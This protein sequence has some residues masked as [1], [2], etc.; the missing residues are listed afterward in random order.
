MSCSIVINQ[1]ASS[2]DPDRVSSQAKIKDLNRSEAAHKGRQ[3]YLKKTKE[4]AFKR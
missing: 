3:N 1:Q 2:S 4:K